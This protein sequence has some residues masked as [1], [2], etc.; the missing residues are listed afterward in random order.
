MIRFRNILF[1]LFLFAP[2]AVFGQPQFDVFEASIAQIQ[3]ALGRGQVSSVQLVQ[4]Y[5][6]RIQAYDRQG[7]KLNSIVRINPEALAKA[8]ALDAERERTGPRSPLHGVP[9]VVKDNYNTDHMPTTGGSV[10][11]V[12][13]IPS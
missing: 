3:D 13:F 5:L 1:S 10:A 8:Q 12:N 2:F 6:D 9:I 4:Q 7:P 11:L